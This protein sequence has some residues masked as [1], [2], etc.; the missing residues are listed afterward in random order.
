MK[1]FKI[2]VLSLMLS[3]LVMPAYAGSGQ[4]LAPGVY[5]LWRN[6]THNYLTNLFISNITD[7]T[8]SGTV[9]LYQTDGTILHDD[10]TADA[11]N[12]I[13]G[14]FATYSESTS[15]G[16][17]TIAFTLSPHASGTV[18]LWMKAAPDTTFKGYA[19]IEW[20]NVDGDDNYG[21]IANGEMLSFINGSP[22]TYTLPINDGRPF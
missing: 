15:T 10:N 7:H 14:D 16:E 9:K 1:H 12:I 17:K 18:V 3:L 5:A 21:L 8:I 19:K 22:A 11:G 6:S 4:A 20:K 13:G 2:L